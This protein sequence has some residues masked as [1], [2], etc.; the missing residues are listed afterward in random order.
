MMH[1]L[2]ACT[3]PVSPAHHGSSENAAAQMGDGHLVS[4]GVVKGD[5]LAGL[6]GLHGA[7]GQVALQRVPV[8][9]VPE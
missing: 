6:G 4:A 7:V 1:S 3:P 9:P 2:T 8:E 5:G